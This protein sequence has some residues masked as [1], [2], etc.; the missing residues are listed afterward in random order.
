MNTEHYRVFRASLEEVRSRISSDGYLNGLL[1]ANLITLLEVYLQSVTVS[2]IESDRRLMVRLAESGVFKKQTIAL[3]R[4]IANDMGRF[5]VAQ[6]KSVV[7]HNL[8]NIEPLFKQAFDLRILV[9]K[10]M[11]GLINLRHDIVHRNGFSISG[12]H[13]DLQEEELL[14]AMKVV[15]GMVTG[16]DAQLV[17]KFPDLIKL[18]D[19]GS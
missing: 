1:M 2:L 7:F 10:D 16:I 15:T 6:V 19:P 17:E 12:A 13:H 4:A 9:T 3:S 18:V 5:L 8:S 11:I 14:A